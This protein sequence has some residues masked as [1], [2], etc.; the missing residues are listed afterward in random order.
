MQT[1]Q[2]T[3]QAYKESHAQQKHK[4]IYDTFFRNADAD[5]DLKRSFQACD[6]FG[7]LPFSW[8]WKLLVDECPQ[9]FRF[10]E[11][12]VYKGRVLAQVG[13]LAN[14]TGKQCELLGVT[15]LSTSG[16]KYSQYADVE[17][18]SEIYKNLQTCGV[19]K[20]RLQI[21]KGFSQDKHIVQQVFE[22]G[23]FDI[24]FVDGSH[25]YENVCIDIYNYG[26]MVKPGGLFVMDDSSLYIPYPYGQFLGH[27]DVSKAAKDYLE[28]NPQFEH[29]FA[30]GHNRVWRKL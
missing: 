15:P 17:Y 27:P 4:Q 29:L 5:N 18:L 7:E 12:G 21:I 24:V 6:G 8:N 20:E 1:L 22:K 2:E 11:I 30:V 19:P 10:L 3:V 23:P 16:D 28:N 26:G 25:D 9:S 13:M 14:R